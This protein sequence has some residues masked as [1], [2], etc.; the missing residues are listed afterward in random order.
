[1]PRSTKLARSGEPQNLHVGA[2]DDAGRGQVARVPVFTC[3]RGFLGD[4]MLWTTG[5]GAPGPS[6]RKAA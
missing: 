4:A 2:A 3:T 5:P 6:S 1:M